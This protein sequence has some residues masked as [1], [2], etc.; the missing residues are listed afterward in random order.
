MWF[1]LQNGQKSLFKL[2]F[3]LLKL[4]NFSILNQK[5]TFVEVLNHV[6][7]INS[8][9]RPINFWMIF[10]HSG[11]SECTGSSYAYARGS[12]VKCMRHVY[13]RR[14]GETYDSPPSLP[15]PP[16]LPSPPPPS[17]LLLLLR[18]K[19]LSPKIGAPVECTMI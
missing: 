18:R 16:S 1:C 3:L 7:N 14:H 4:S 12:F 9:K 13:V 15:P 17:R 19:K 5:M 10:C 11:H 8:A 2:I 6:L